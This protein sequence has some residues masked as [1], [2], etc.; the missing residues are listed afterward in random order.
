MNGLL[1]RDDLSGP[2]GQETRKE[3]R[4]DYKDV[5]TATLSLLMVVG[6]FLL[7][8]VFIELDRLRVADVDLAKADSELAKAISDLKP[9]LID[10][11]AFDKHVDREERLIAELHKE[12]SS[13]QTMI[14]KLHVE[15][16]SFRANGGK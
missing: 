15:V 16:V 4:M 8:R 9:N 14:Q 6:G 13:L 1:E 12:I 11:S 5:L 3:G 2:S 7:N 10:R